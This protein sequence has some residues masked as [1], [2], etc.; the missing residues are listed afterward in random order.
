MRRLLF[1]GR[2][3]GP[4]PPRHNKGMLVTCARCEG[5]IRIPTPDVFSSC[6]PIIC[7]ACVLD[8]IEEA[9]KRWPR[10]RPRGQDID[11][12]KWDEGGTS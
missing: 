12:A 11:M 7:G 8:D 1:L 3:I 2:M 4:R 10:P 9:R 6:A 5:S